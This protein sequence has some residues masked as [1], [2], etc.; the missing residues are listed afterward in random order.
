M[1]FSQCICVDSTEFSIAVTDFF[2]AVCISLC[3]S[4]KVCLSQSV[5][6]VISCFNLYYNAVIIYQQLSLGYSAHHS[7]EYKPRRNNVGSQ[8]V[9][10]WWKG[11]HPE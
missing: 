1:N 4:A 10:S 2:A 5:D 8:G 7:V 9:Q 3:D 11:Q 6:V